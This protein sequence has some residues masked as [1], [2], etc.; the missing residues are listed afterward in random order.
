MKIEDLDLA[1]DDVRRD[2]L[3]ALAALNRPDPP[4]VVTMRWGDGSPRRVSCAICGMGLT[5]QQASEG[6]PAGCTC[7]TMP[8]CSDCGSMT[9]ERSGCPLCGEVFC[10]SCAEKPYEFCCGN[11]EP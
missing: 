6:C 5:G 7:V 8:A 2:V 4:V 3:R 11:G 1:P 10:Q 9:A